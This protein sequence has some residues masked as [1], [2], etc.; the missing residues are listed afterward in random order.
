MATSPGTTSLNLDASNSSS[1]EVFS[2]PEVQTKE[3]TAPALYVWETWQMDILNHYLPLYKTN[4][5]VRQRTAILDKTL[6]KMKVKRDIPDADVS[7]L[8]KA[9]SSCKPFTSILTYG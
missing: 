9:S 6:R 3:Y 7:G 2:D 4:K 1:A 8:R 5:T